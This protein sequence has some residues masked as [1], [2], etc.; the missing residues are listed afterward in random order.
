[1]DYDANESDPRAPT[2]LVVLTAIVYAASI[3]TVVAWFALLLLGQS[4]AAPR[5]AVACGACG[6]VQAVRELAPAPGEP[7]EGSRAEGAVFLLAALGGARAADARSA[8]TYETA[9]LLDDGFLRVLRDTQR[10]EWQRGD[11]VRVIMGRVVRERPAAADASAT[12]AA[13]GAPAGRTPSPVPPIG[14]GQ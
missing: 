3:A 5:P 10:P 2:A 14:Q 1:M 7:L 8:K 11:R 12:V 13:A 4:R 9:V 6:V